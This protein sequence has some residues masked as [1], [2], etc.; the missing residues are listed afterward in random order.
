MMEMQSLLQNQM[1]PQSSNLATRPHPVSP[2]Q[3]SLTAISI[4]LWFSPWFLIWITGQPCKARRHALYM[5]D[6]QFLIPQA[7]VQ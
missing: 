1:H 3:H 2:P 6:K 5:A 4:T 7:V